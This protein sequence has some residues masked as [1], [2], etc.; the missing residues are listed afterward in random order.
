MTEFV[1]LRSKMCS[2]RIN[3]QDSVKKVK[4]VKT[5]FVNTPNVIIL[6]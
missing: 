1:V 5:V 2:I 4:G 6:I 3:G